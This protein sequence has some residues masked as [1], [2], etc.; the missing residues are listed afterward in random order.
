ML[1]S[2][3]FRLRILEILSGLALFATSA[4]ADL[5]ETLS[6]ENYVAPA[7][8]QVTLTGL[9]STADAT[10]WTYNSEVLSGLSAQ[11]PHLGIIAGSVLST[12]NFSPA[13]GPLYFQDVFGNGGYLGPKTILGP[14]MPGVSSWR[15]FVVPSTTPAGTYL[16][17]YGPLFTTNTPSPVIQLDNFALTVTPPLLTLANLSKN[18]YSGAAQSYGGYSAITTNCG[19][20]PA[21]CP[22]D[23]FRAVAFATPDKSQV[24]IAF[25]GTDF[26]DPATGLKNFAADTSFTTNTPS[27]NLA[28]SVSY[29]AQF[30]HTVSEL[31]P[32]ANISLTGHSLGGA[33]AQ[34]VGQASGLTTVAFNAPG[35]ASLYNQLTSQLAPASGIGSGGTNTNYRVYGDQV[36]L[37]GQPIGTTITLPA[38]AGTV[39]VLP[40][41]PVL[42]LVDNLST[43]LS[44]HSIA[45]VISELNAQPISS[46]GEPD[47]VPTLEQV[48]QGA[49]TSSPST[50][51]SIF[52][53]VFD[54]V[55][56]SGYLID[57]SAGSD[58]TLIEQTGSPFF[59]SIDLPTLNGI[60]A[61]KLRYEVGN[62]WFPFQTIQPGTQD[63]LGA[64][65]D[66]IEFNPVDQRG[67]DVVVPALLFDAAFS[68]TGTFSGTLT[69][70]QPTPE[71]ASFYLLG[72]TVAITILARRGW[73]KHQKRI[74][75][76]PVNLGRTICP[77][78]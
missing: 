10:T 53:I 19:T 74:Q 41:D 47:V 68:S 62:T 21:Q 38:P 42:E 31:Y 6:P 71:P 5:L 44:L 2:R 65:V 18:V 49:L 73:K 33:I 69:E 27:A 67:N 35:G 70:V 12:A 4:A 77:C 48:V 34:L 32:G 54:V 8:G 9:F 22:Y 51:V 76:E 30:V 1:A 40:G 60:T 37:A 14:Q 78:G 64:G 15:T 16:Y 50:G 20:L 75:S 24:V 72:S 43:F 56:L 25:R 61:Y 63:F 58:F 36:S 11:S 29:A 66:G 3:V 46:T 57:P 23:G 7:G 52:Q 59:A 28:L 45:T 55:D 13:N 26:G 39:F 17:S